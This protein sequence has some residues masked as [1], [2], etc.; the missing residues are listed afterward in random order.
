MGQTAL[1]PHRRKSCYGLLSPL[2]VYRVRLG[3]NTRTLGQIAITLTTRPL[4]ATFQKLLMH[5][6]SSDEV[7]ETIRVKNVRSY[8]IE[9]LLTLNTDSLKQ[10]S[11]DFVSQIVPFNFHRINVWHNKK[12]S[13][14]F[15]IGLKVK[16]VPLH[17][18]KV[19][20]GRRV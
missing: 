1:L 9:R 19:L 17:A 18:M 7:S 5:V 2:T 20:M 14:K 12:I 16:S 4:R 10:V 15:S 3:S 8:S 6:S 11:S 13:N